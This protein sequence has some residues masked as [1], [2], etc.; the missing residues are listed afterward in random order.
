MVEQFRKMRENF[1]KLRAER[2]RKTAEAA[3]AKITAESDD[4]EEGDKPK[5]EEASRG[6]PRPSVP[7]PKRRTSPS[8]SVGSAGDDDNYS[9]DSVLEDVPE[10]D[11]G[12]PPDAID[13]DGMQAAP[14]PMDPGDHPALKGKIEEAAD[15]RARNRAGKVA[16]SNHP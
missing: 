13:I 7:K 15:K 14:E 16:P 1:A 10:D 8:P 12:I 2:A 5:A 11:D 6:R 4:E 9:L 3:A